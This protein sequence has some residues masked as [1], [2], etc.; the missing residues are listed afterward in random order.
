MRKR[1]GYLLIDNSSGPGISEADL[2]KLPRKGPMLA[3]PEGKKF[4]ANTL[5]CAHCHVQLLRNPLRTRERGSCGLCHSYLCDWCGAE[6]GRTRECKHLKSRL[7]QMQ[8]QAFLR[9]QAGL[10]SGEILISK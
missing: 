8:E 4:E 9:E 2:A 7:D 10:P 6:Y 5:T 3:V 1:E